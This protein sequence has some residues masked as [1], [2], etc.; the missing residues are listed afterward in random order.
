MNNSPLLAIKNLH[1]SGLLKGVSLDLFPGEVVA[2][3]GVSGSGKTLTAASIMGLL[4]P[5]LQITEGEILYQERALHTLSPQE[6]LTIRGPHIGI[7]FQD[8]LTHLNPTRSIGKQIAEMLRFHEGRSRKEARLAACD[9]LEEVGL[10]SSRYDDYPFQ[11]SG[12]QRQRVMIAMALACRPAL[13]LADEPTTA[14]DP[15]TQKQILELLQTLIKQRGTSLL[16]ITHDLRIANSI[17]NRIAVM[18]DGTIVESGPKEQLFTSP[19]H[20]QTQALMAQYRRM[21]EKKPTEARSLPAIESPSLFP[22]VLENV[23]KTYPQ[24]RRHHTAL[25]AINLTIHPGETI[26]IVGASGAGKST[27]GRLVAQMETPTSGHL[28]FGTFPPRDKKGFRKKVQMIFQDHTDVLNPMMSV[29]DIVAE[30]L[31]IHKMATGERRTKQIHELLTAVGL[32]IEFME[33]Y[34]HQLSGGQRQRVGIARALAVQPECLVCDE[35]F[36]AL[37]LCTQEQILILL[38]Q[39]QQKH[40]LTYLLI[41]HDADVVEAFADR[42]FEVKEP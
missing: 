40:N 36:A 27:L 23:G 39:L 25:H 5:Q 14:L 8:P 17:A 3:V 4:P 20:P 7:I 37:D 19:Q 41:T 6:W 9:L 29:G 12:G 1:V 21:L 2:L 32:P 26:A 34:P 11:L 16:F 18:H 10:P 28:Q 24:K 33:R 22:I 30:G 31:D 13:L 35:P 38:K 15:E 42:I